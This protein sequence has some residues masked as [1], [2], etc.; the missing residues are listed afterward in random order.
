MLI[1][2]FGAF[3]LLPSRYVTKVGTNKLVYLT[4]VSGSVASLL[5]IIYVVHAYSQ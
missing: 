2:K 1:N 3:S 4:Y 5:L